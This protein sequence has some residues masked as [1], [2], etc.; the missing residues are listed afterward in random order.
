[1]PCQK[2]ER[3]GLL[4]V[5]VDSIVLRLCVWDCLASESLKC[6]FQKS[7]FCNSHSKHSASAVQKGRENTNRA[8]LLAER[9]FAPQR[10]ACGSTQQGR[11]SG[12]KRKSWFF[13][14]FF[15]LSFVLLSCPSRSPRKSCVRRGSGCTVLYSRAGSLSSVFLAP[16]CRRSVVATACRKRCTSLPP[17]GQ[18]WAFRQPR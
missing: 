6:W 17:S 12:Y 1:M 4:S 9:S 8:E 2:T 16:L 13:S 15:S 14:L 10:V 18:A 11:G 3:P 5:V 7:H